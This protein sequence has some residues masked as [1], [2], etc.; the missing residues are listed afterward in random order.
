MNLKM[1]LEGRVA[2]KPT[3]ALESEI[4]IFFDMSSDPAMRQVF[5]IITCH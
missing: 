5:F 3:S 4:I 1:N 2:G